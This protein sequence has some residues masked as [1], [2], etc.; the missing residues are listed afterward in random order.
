MK[1]KKAC[2]VL[3]KTLK[4]MKVKHYADIRQRE[5]YIAVVE[6]IQKNCA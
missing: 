6:R 2:K 5:H 1:V 3:K 4:K